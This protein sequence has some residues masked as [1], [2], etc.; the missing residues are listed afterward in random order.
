MFVSF[1]DPV[2]GNLRIYVTNKTSSGNEIY[3]RVRGDK[4]QESE[5]YTR[6]LNETSAE[7][8]GGGE[9]G[10]GG[11]AGFQ[12]GGQGGIKVAHKHEEESR[13]RRVFSCLTQGGFTFLPYGEVTPFAVENNDRLMY[14]SVHDGSSSWC[15]NM[16]VN[17]QQYGCVT[18]KEDKPS[19]ISV[20]PSNPEPRW[21]QEDKGNPAFPSDAVKV[22]QRSDHVVVYLAKVNLKFD[23]LFMQQFVFAQGAQGAQG[24]VFQ[25]PTGV[26][27]E[28]GKLCWK[29]R[30]G[31][32]IDTLDLLRARRYE[33]VKAQRG[34]IMPPNAVKT[35]FKEWCVGR[36]DGENIC[37]VSITDGM[38]D[39]FTDFNGYKL[40]TSGDILLLT[41]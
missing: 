21:V 26:W 40:T 25:Y 27:R 32:E 14:I 31:L 35:G 13:K 28:N 4:L 30:S 41:V 37:A 19:R 15:W 33:W 9:A 8:S 23:N 3:V 12:H 24:A 11:K 7:I 1:L 6:I 17:P 2:P 10:Q 29:S 39:Y 38:I 36:V 16:Q 5:D 20:F 18:I 34:N 22:Y